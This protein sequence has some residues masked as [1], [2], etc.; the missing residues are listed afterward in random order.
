MSNGLI[1]GVMTMTVVVVVV[2]VEVTVVVAGF[3]V[4]GNLAGDVGG[5]LVI[6]QLPSSGQ[7][8]SESTSSQ[9]KANK[10]LT[11]SPLQGRNGRGDVGAGLGVVECGRGLTVVTTGTVEPLPA[12]E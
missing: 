2:I 9:N 5:A 3:V 4:K 11:H 10:P 7:W 8:A 1:S 12:S 6:Q